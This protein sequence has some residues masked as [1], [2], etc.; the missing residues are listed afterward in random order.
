MHY[1][2][3]LQKLLDMRQEKEDEK[4]RELMKAMSHKQQIEK[5]IKQFE[6]S[7]DEYRQIPLEK[8]IVEKKIT[9]RYLNSLTSLIEENKKELK[10]HEKITE[11]KRIELVSAQV[12][13]KTVEILKE[14][15]YE[16]AVKEA[17]LKEQNQIDEFALYGYVR[18]E[19]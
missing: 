4:K 16:R 13:R 7:Y 19:R 9:Q 12:E 14:K 18:R 8:S 3:R 17:A 2:F 6:E 1:K 11:E 15:D 5:K 10:K